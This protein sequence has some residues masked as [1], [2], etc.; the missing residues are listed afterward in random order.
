MLWRYVVSIGIWNCTKPSF[1][2][3]SFTLLIKVNVMFVIHGHHIICGDEWVRCQYGNHEIAISIGKNWQ[4]SSHPCPRVGPRWQMPWLRLC[5]LWHRPGSHQGAKVNRCWHESGGCCFM[6]FLYAEFHDVINIPYIQ[7]HSMILCHGDLLMG[8][9]GCVTD[10]FACGALRVWVTF[11]KRAE[12]KLA[13]F[14]AWYSL[15]HGVSMSVQPAFLLPV[16]L[17]E[18]KHIILSPPCFEVINGKAIHVDLAESKQDQFVLEKEVL[19]K[20]RAWKPLP[21]VDDMYIL[22][23]LF[24]LQQCILAVVA[25]VGKYKMY[26]CF[27]L[28]SVSAFGKHMD[29]CMKEMKFMPR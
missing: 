19:E 12:V 29:S 17:Y 1:Q 25:A 7:Y 13:V 4:H 3:V 27:A 28:F 15:S 22:E 23:A 26:C 20:R 2:P 5:E 10:A 18:R 6:L 8:G 14:R 11:S 16:F 21:L 9:A 24:H